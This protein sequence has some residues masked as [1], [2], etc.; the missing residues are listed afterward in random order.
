MPCMSSNMHCI[1]LTSHLAYCTWF[2]N[3]IFCSALLHLSLV[4][5]DHQ[6]IQVLI[7]SSR[8]GVATY[9]VKLES[10]GIVVQQ[11]DVDA[12]SGDRIELKKLTQCR[13][14]TITVTEAGISAVLQ[15]QTGGCSARPIIVDGWL[16]YCAK[17]IYYPANTI[18]RW[19]CAFQRQNRW[20]QWPLRISPAGSNVWLCSNDNVC[21]SSL[22]PSGPETTPDSLFWTRWPE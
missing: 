20:L 13:N 16:Y 12:S 1:T 9:A 17:D 18:F 19:L 15:A 6:Q 2:P 14:Y 10:D 21:K 8:T 11:I 7:N 5:M 22:F 3:R 4:D